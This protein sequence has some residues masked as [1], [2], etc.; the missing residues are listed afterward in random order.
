MIHLSQKIPHLLIKIG[1]L[2]SSLWRIKK[3]Y[4]FSKLELLG[5]REDE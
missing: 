1:N 5:R 2:F 4:N 3:F